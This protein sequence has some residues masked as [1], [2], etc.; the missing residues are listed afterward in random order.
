MI[1]RVTATQ[2]TKPWKRLGGELLAAVSRDF[3]RAALTPARA[4]WPALIQPRGLAPYDNAGADLI[5]FKDGGGIDVVIQ[6]KGL[7]KAEGLQDDQFSQF[8]K[9]ITSFRNSGLA[10]RP[11]SSFTTRMAAIRPSRRRSTALS[12][13]W[14][15]RDES[16]RPST[17]TGSA[18]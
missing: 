3:E 17:G 16:R 14:W 10:P 5:A 7:F 13:T 1:L 18:F 4:F 6:C 11:T 15:P 8:R 12:L 9:S 2:G